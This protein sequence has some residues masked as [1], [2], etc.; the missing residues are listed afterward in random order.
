M[1]RRI[2]ARQH[3]TEILEIGA[4]TLNH[5][6]YEPQELSYDA[7]EPFRELW[8]GRAAVSQLRRLYLS[9]EEIP[10]EVKYDRII[11]VAVLEHLTDLPRMVAR[12]ALH[13]RTNGLF[14]A[15]IPSEG[16]ALW[17]ISWR[18]STG[19]AFHLRTGLSYA[20]L[21]RH[22]HVNTAREILEICNWLFE[23]V[24]IERFPTNLHHLSFYAVLE[25]RGP[26]LDRCRQLLRDQTG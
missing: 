16:G 5:L 21:M 1:H 23:Q 24:E 19:I 14:Q 25:A 15:G 12:A 22:E 7:V 18:L 10:K 9:A 17:G 11:S 20:E 2:A 26:R 6:L 4:G 13:L 8:D 3:G